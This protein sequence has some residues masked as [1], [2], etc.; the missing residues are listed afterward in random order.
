MKAMLD[1]LIPL[2]IH[3]R[4]RNREKV[5][6]RSPQRLYVFVSH[7]DACCPVIRDTNSSKGIGYEIGGAVRHNS[8]RREIFMILKRSEILSWKRVTLLKVSTSR[9]TMAN[10]LNPGRYL[11]RE[12]RPSRVVP[13]DDCT[14]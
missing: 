1:G 3:V 14:D 6:S 9:A 8:K 7:V 2:T 11:R 10:S 12:K 4:R 5:Y 13:H